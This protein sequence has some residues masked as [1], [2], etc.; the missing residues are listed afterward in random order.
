[1]AAQEATPPEKLRAI[2]DEM[3]AAHA[4]GRRSAVEVAM[5]KARLEDIVEAICAA[6]RGAMSRR[7]R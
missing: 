3:E 4:E 7:R 1:M 6:H 5:W 2:A